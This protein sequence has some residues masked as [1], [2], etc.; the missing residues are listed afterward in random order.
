[1]LACLLCILSAGLAEAQGL[2]PI[3]PDDVDEALLQPLY[4]KVKAIAQQTGEP[5]PGV[6]MTLK[7]SVERNRF[8]KR[9]ETDAAGECRLD[10]PKSGG[11]S[12][13]SIEGKVKG[14]VP[15]YYRYDGQNRKL[16]LPEEVELAFEPA[17]SIG[18]VVQDEVG[19]PIAGVKVEVYIP[20]TRSSYGNS[21]VFHITDTT[22]DDKGRWRSD[23][24]PK[25]MSH[26]NISFEHGDYL[27]SHIHGSGEKPTLM[28]IEN[29]K[30]L[31]QGGLVRGRVLDEAGQPIAGAKLRYGSSRFDSS[32][33]Q[34]RTGEDG[35]FTL[36]NCSAGVMPVTVQADGYAPDMRLVSVVGDGD[37]S[38]TVA[39]FMAQ[40]EANPAEKPQVASNPIE[41][42]LKPPAKL[43]GRVV[44]PAGKPLAGVGIAADTW[45]GHRA[46]E[47]R[48]NTD[49]EGRFAWDNAPP[50]D[51]VQYDLFARERM[52]IRN[53]VIPADGEEHTLVMLPEITIKGT[54]RDAETGEPVP[55]FQLIIGRKYRENSS[56]YW[57]RERG[58]NEFKRGE[59]QLTFDEPQFETKL[60]IEAPGRRPYETES[61]NLA[62]GDREFDIELVRGE[63]FMGQVVDAQGKPVPKAGLV[64]LSK[65]TR[66][67]GL[68]GAAWSDSW[69]TP[70]ATADDDGKYQFPEQ[71]E[72]VL[73]VAVHEAGIGGLLTDRLG[74]ELPAI[75]LTPWGRIEGRVMNGNQ[76]AAGA[77]V[78]VNSYNHNPVGRWVNGIGEI[79]VDLSD[80]AG[81]QNGNPAV[82]TLERVAK[83]VAP[84]AAAV[85][86]GKQ[87]SKAQQLLREMQ[88]NVWQNFDLVTD[89]QGQFAFAYAL[90]GDFTVYKTLEVRRGNGSTQ[91][92]THST[93]GKIEAGGVTKVVIGGVGR[94]VVGRI[95]FPA[96][97]PAGFDWG[98]SDPVGLTPAG[99][100]HTQFQ[101]LVT[102]EGSFRIEDV[103]PGEYELGFTARDSTSATDRWNA[104][105]LGFVKK[106][107]A[108]PPPADG[109]KW[110]AEPVEVGEFTLTPS[111]AN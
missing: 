87:D 21:F 32:S 18:G 56:L 82:T 36:K 6:A 90:P 33:A 26:L 53:E 51:E 81:S 84:A 40:P 98:M 14:Y 31:S 69:S 15:I 89:A 73:I 7:T 88:P 35:N 9:A 43:R 47:W 92:A 111:E 34:T 107:I 66:S 76:A 52:S 5:L 60:R 71:T 39:T 106:T 74:G 38:A 78:R 41:F 91:Y 11:M 93:P 58:D 28:S 2:L 16:D 68:Q 42:R 13:V 103:P 109:A 64:L 85:I 1:M 17:V 57:N 94:P 20:A 22:T 23:F 29:V 65:E 46:L 49:A 63:P 83:V 62:D 80:P 27:K 100:P 54:V 75:K 95:A 61:F 72:A 3:G 70:R 4:V 96:G 37:R 8:E 101:G 48:S 45:R 86:R 12:Y 79:Q 99:K 77:Q 25:D 110:S 59:F 67:A 55:E 30:T 108:V 105:S 24:A 19:E 50:V 97:A 102:P 10:L 104:P 44:D